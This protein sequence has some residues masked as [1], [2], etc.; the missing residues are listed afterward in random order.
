M[1]RIVR[2]RRAPRSAEAST[3]DSGTRSSA[4]Y[5]G[6]IMNG[7]HIYEKTTHIATFVYPMLAGG[8]PIDCRLQL[9]SALWLRIRIHAYTRAREHAHRRS[10]TAASANGC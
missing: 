4:A 2:Q 3:S 5:V 6:M 1:S 10:R 8:R 9:S 7:S